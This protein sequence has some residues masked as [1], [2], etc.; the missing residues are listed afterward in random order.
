MGRG[1]GRG[2]GEKGERGEID[3]ER[4]GAEE[5]ILKETRGIG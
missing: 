5:E 3:G 2:R 1:C 4:E